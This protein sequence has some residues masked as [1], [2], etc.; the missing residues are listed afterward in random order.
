M[1]VI[2]DVMPAFQLFQPTSIADAQKLLEQHGQRC[3]GDG[4]RHGQLRLAEGSHQE[5][6]SGGRSERNRGTQG[7]S[8]Y[9]DG[10]EIGAM[11]TLTEVVQPSRHQREVWIAGAG[12]GTGGVAADPQSGH[13]RRQRL[14]GRALLVLPRGL[15][16]LSRG[17][18]HL[19]CRYSGGPEPRACDSACRAMRGSESVRYS[20]GADRARRQ[21][22]GSHSQGRARARCRGLFRRSR[23]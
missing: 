16:V 8:H 23:N 13:A 18:K 2:R 3:L 9:A 21:V 19:L 15:A 22:R 20:S 6:Q 17:R 14:A 10:I 4:G 7:H 5:T 1:A 12:G 11:T